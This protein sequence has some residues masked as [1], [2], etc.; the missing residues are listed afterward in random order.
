[1]HAL[2]K[3]AVLALISL[4]VTLL[5]LQACVLHSTH[6]SEFFPC[7]PHILSA[8]SFRYLCVLY[9][10][11]L[12][13]SAHSTPRFCPLSLQATASFDMTWRLWDVEKGMCLSEQEGHSRPVYT[14]A[15]HPDGSLAASAGLDSIGK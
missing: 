12:L 7:F 6:C 11:S 1:M 14:V 10:L 3:D 2:G 4:A 5:S 8:S 9:I 15:F 13:S